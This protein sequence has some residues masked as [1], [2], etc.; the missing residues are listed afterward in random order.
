MTL[1]PALLATVLYVLFFYIDICPVINHLDRTSYKSPSN[2]NTLA[3]WQGVLLGQAPLT[4]QKMGNWENA[5]LSGASNSTY[6]THSSFK[7]AQIHR[8]NL[9]HDLDWTRPHLTFLSKDKYSRCGRLNLPWPEVSMLS[10][11]EIGWRS[12]MNVSGCEGEWGHSI[13]YMRSV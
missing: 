7:E 2:Q 10:R 8:H 3:M 12:E 11:H 13:T 4:F 9:N 5:I 1:S 6:I